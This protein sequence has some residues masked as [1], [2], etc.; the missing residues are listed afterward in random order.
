M[1]TSFHVSHSIFNSLY[2]FHFSYH[3]ISISIVKLYYS[4]TPI[5]KTQ[6]WTDTRI[7]PKH[8]SFAPSASSDNSK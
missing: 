8:T 7:Q 5:N 4:F 6:T 3:F 1:N 2:H